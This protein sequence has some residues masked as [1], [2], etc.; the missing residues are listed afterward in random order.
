MS[1]WTWKEG[2][3]ADGD[4]SSGWM[5]VKKEGGHPE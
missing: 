2:E 4:C 5:K 1:E 3:R